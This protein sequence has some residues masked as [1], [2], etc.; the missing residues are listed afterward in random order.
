MPCTLLRVKA[1]HPSATVLGMTGAHKIH[2]DFAPFPKR[3]NAWAPYEAV[4]QQT[5]PID[6]FK[7]SV[8]LAA[9]LPTSFIFC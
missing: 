2:P 1:N 8:Q 5:P 9:K 7:R 6:T 3:L 4:E